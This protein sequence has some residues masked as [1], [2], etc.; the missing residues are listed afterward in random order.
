RRSGRRH[1]G[2]PPGAPPR[3]GFTDPEAIK[4]IFTGDRA[5]LRAGEAAG[6]ILGPIIGWHSI[7]LLDGERHHRERRLMAPPLHGERMHVYGRLMREIADRVIDAWPVG[8]PFPIHHE[9]QAI[10]LDVILRAV[11]GVDEGTRFA[12][13]REN[14]VRFLA[15][16]DSP[17]AAFLAIQAF[18]VELG[19]LSPWGR[20]V[21]NRE[22]IRTELLAEIGRRRREGTEGRTDI[23]SMLVEARDD[24]GEPM[25]DA[26]LID[27]MFTLLMAGHETTATS[28][29]WAFHHLLEHPDVLAKLRAELARVVGE[30]P[31]EPQH[32]PQLEYLDA[33][34]KESQRLCPVATN[35]IRRLTQ[36]MRIGG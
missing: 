30:G 9:M 19:G 1:P 21:R 11:F 33:V 27:E 36:P 5:E 29:A 7:L 32:I 28:L 25:T 12:R 16:A 26:E 17:T 34:I 13:V 18:Q 14:I 15:Q 10:T 24:R 6:P 22:T 20:F 4:E 31:V 8:Q 2:P 23:L 35:V 3:V